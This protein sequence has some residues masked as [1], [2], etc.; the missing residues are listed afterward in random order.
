MHPTVRI[1]ETVGDRQLCRRSYFRRSLVHDRVTEHTADN[2]AQAAGCLSSTAL[3][4]SLE[5]AQ[6]IRGMDVLD[7][8]LRE[9]RGTIGQEPFRLLKGRFGGTSLVHALDVVFNELAER[10]ARGCFS[11]APVDTLLERRVHAVR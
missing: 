3:F 11:L 7:R 9:R 2:A 6:D 10:P 8:S 5:D 1:V 4:D